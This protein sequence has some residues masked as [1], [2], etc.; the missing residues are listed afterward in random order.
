[1]LFYAHKQKELIVNEEQVQKQFEVTV[2]KPSDNNSKNH[3]KVSGFM[4]F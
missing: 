2:N 1:M 3:N 4:E